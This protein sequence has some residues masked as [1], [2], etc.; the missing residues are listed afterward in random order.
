M[1]IT[2][3]NFTIPWRALVSA[4]SLAAAV[5]CAETAAF[6]AARPVWPEGEAETL[7]AFFSFRGEFDAA[8]GDD[9]RLR[10]TAGYVYKAWLNGALET[11]GTASPHIPTPVS[12]SFT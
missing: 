3:F 11:A 6:D 1:T 5:A 9:V 12:H 2:A 10:A 8:E 4:A 7:N